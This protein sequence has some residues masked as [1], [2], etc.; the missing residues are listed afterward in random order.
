[1]CLITKN[2]RDR[3]DQPTPL[4]GWIKPSGITIR[5]FELTACDPAT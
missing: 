1:M 3:K 2:E 5:H 4:S